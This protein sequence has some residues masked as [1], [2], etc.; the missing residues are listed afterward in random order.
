MDKNNN[1][2]ETKNNLIKVFDGLKI[3]AIYYNTPEHP[4]M[5]VVREFF[6]HKEGI[7][8]GA[9]LGIAKTLT[10]ARKYLP[11]YLHRFSR[12]PEDDAE[13]IETWF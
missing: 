12:T 5:F 6:S 7:T 8:L 13:L 10:E 3:I 4:G 1:E 2:D 11:P 9:I